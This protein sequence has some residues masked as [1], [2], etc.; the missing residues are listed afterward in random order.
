MEFRLAR[1]RLGVPVLAVALTGA[2]LAAPSAAHTAGDADH[3]AVGPAGIAAQD[4]DTIE[5]RDLDAACP[6][7]R[8]PSGSFPDAQ[9]PFTRAIECLVWYDVTQGRDDGT[10]GISASVTRGQMA[11]FL[12]RLLEYNLG[13]EAVPGADVEHDFN[14]VPDQAELTA[15]VNALSSE[16]L[17]EFLGLDAPP[18]RGY[19]DDTYRPGQRVER[20]QMASFVARVFDG[21]LTLYDGRITQ[22]GF[23]TFPDSSEIPDVHRDSVNT[24]CGFGIATGRGDGTF[25]PRE[26]VTRGQMAAFLMRTQDLVA[27][28]PFY[29]LLPDQDVVTVDRDACGE[30]A[31]G[32]ADAPFCTAQEGVTAADAGDRVQIVASPDFYPEDVDL[33]SGGIEVF[34]IPVADDEDQLLY[35]EIE[36]SVT[37]DT[38][39]QR[40]LLGRLVVV[41]E[42][43]RA[44]L[45]L[46]G[47]G[48]VALASLLVVG[49]T[50]GIDVTADEAK[51][52]AVAVHQADVGVALDVGGGD[53][54]GSDFRQA[55][56]FIVDRGGSLDL[57]EI[58]ER[59]GLG[60]SNFFFPEAEVGEFDGSPAI[61]PAD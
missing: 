25:G 58:L 13:G 20:A 50:T 12:Y 14:D 45:T 34:G 26:A 16:E 1:R 49:G 5:A 61:V 9:E 36:G 6:E 21:L 7:G 41:P 37:G 47:G 29:A 53:V 51:L 4:D 23:C 31:D 32:S 38:A 3:G 48:D 33:G 43:G 52:D 59:G 35:P 60:L 44:G 10:Y 40:I 27:D 30:S 57:E 39:G 15:A 18:V 54:R 24:V 19:A 8:V 2:L 56:A 42:Q 28:E 11:L 46:T 22:Q 55:D 17:A